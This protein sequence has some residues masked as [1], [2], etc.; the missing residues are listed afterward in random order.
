M[1]KE[2]NTEFSV[3]RI[4]DATL[5]RFRG[6]GHRGEGRHGGDQEHCQRSGLPYEDRCVEQ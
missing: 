1:R 4:P 5:S 6:G 2:E 3:D